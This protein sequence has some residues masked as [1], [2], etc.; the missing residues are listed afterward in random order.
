MG[1]PVVQCDVNDP[2]RPKGAIEKALALLAELQAAG[3]AVRLSELGRRLDLPKSTAHRT[4]TI[5]ADAG[6]VIRSGNRYRAV[7]TRPG[8]SQNRSLDRE[9]CWNLRPFVGDILVRTGLTASLAVLEDT[10][11]AFVYR[12]YGHEDV[13]T[14]SDESGRA[15]A[16]S[17]AAGRLLLAFDRVKTRAVTDSYGLGSGEAIT[18]DQN[19]SKIK[20]HGF[21]LRHGDGYSCV[22][23]PLLVANGTWRVALTVRGKTSRIDFARTLYALRCVADVAARAS[24]SQQVEPDLV[25]PLPRLGGGSERTFKVGGHD[26]GSLP[27]WSA[28]SA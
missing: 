2:A 1:R 18:L 6:L 24:L 8:G 11:V 22:A 21:A 17:S 23:I 3:C 14:P 25:A 20:R 5:L 28:S 13:R 26:G 16:Y 9:T 19:L 7:F 12:V 10:D 4:L 27:R 15:C